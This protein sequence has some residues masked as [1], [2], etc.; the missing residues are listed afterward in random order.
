MEW[1]R[2]NLNQTARD[3]AGN[4]RC[5]CFR[6][7]ATGTTTVPLT[8]LAAG[9]PEFALNLSTSGTGSGSF[10]CDTGSGAEACEAE[11]EE[12]TTVEVIPVPASGSEFV[13]WTGD[14]SGSGTCEVTMNAEHNVGAVFD[15]EPTLTINE[16]GSGTGS[17]ECK[18]DGGSAEPCDGTASERHQCLN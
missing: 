15:L 18:F 13:E 12:S 6:F 2:P 17:V 10:E 5:L 14:C 8:S 7:W 1:S 3:R 11:Y 16:T 4:V 9:P